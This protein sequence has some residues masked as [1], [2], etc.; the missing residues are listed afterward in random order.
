MWS[1]PGGL[2]FFIEPV[3]SYSDATKDRIA[4]PTHFSIMPRMLFAR[5]VA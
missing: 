5:H 4:E 2:V 1:K 3:S